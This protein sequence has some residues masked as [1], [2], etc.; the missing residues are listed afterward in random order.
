MARRPA[1]LAFPLL[2]SV[3]VVAC[4]S[5]GEDAHDPSRPAN[6]AGALVEADA[7][8]EAGGASAYASTVLADKPIA[9]WTLG[10]QAGTVVARDRVG[11]RDGQYDRCTLGAPGVLA[12][13]TAA[14]FAEDT[15]SIIV[16]NGF[17]FA[18]NAPFTVELWIKPAVSEKLF[19]HAFTQEWNDTNGRQGFAILID[20]GSYA[21]ERFVDGSNDGKVVAAISV[22]PDVFT[23]VVATYDGARMR[24]YVDG[25]SIGSSPDTRP[26]P[27]REST[28]FIGASGKGQQ[29][30]DGVLDEVAV[31]AT[32]L[33]EARIR[34]HHEAGLAR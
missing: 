28:A 25:G 26:L 13:D 7:S 29:V 12:A 10:E 9:Y 16:P 3:I 8:G 2:A 31:Y 24:L 14:S 30:I 34:A 23:H 5:F 22:V 4:S 17:D 20:Y 33:D 18:G 1:E 6:D 11:S 27:S 19:R 15:S 32:A 21:F